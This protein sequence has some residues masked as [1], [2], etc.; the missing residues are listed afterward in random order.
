MRR[1]SRKAGWL[2]GV[3]VCVVVAASGCGGREAAPPEDAT[4][5]YPAPR[6]PR[7]LAKVDLQGETALQWARLAVRQTGGRAPLGRAQSGQVV[8]VLI[9]HGQNMDVWDVIQKAWAERGV[10]AHALGAWEVMGI[11]REEYYARMKPDLVYANQA[12]KE[13]GI[14]RREYRSFFSEAIQKEFGE[15]LTDD[16]VRRTYMVKFLDDH[17]EIQHLFAG[18]GCPS[19]WQRALGEKHRDKLEGNWIFFRPNDLLA[20]ISEFPGDVWTMVDDKIVKPIVNVSEVTITDP[21]GTKLH[22]VLTRDQARGWSSR[23]GAAGHLNIYPSPLRS[24]LKEG[25]IRSAANHTGF[26]PTMTVRLSEH[27]RVLSV[28]GGG[29]TGD[30]FRTLVTHPKMA[31]AQFPSSPEPGYWFLTQDGFGTNPKFVRNMEAAVE[32]TVWN[33]ISAERNRAGVQHFSFS[34][35]ATDELPADVAYAKEQGLP[36]EHTAHMHVYF[37]TV[38]WRMADTGEW[39]TLAENGMVKVFE[40]D[41]EVRALAAKYGDPDLLFRYEWIPDLPGINVPGDYEKDYAP[42]P[43]AYILGQWQKMQNG[44][45]A[46]YVEDYPF[47]S[48]ILAAPPQRPIEGQ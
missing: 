8:H 44:T 45:Y 16:Y 14:F 13:M 38:R 31:N 7:Y 11:T 27:G 18:Q 48:L 29:K 9:P 17:P 25:V 36:L 43:W 23:A 22:F 26:Y 33:T 32:G 4:A 2:A 35:P 3:T 41:P 20:K 21:E 10:E 39:M 5:A 42:D 1:L 40:N 6:F 34:H 12:W 24:T 47:Q 30:L 19:C 46:Y 37:P 15:P 28:E